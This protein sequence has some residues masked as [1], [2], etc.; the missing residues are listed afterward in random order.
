MN[1]KTTL[2][3]AVLCA[4]G[5]VFYW[6]ESSG[7]PLLRS[8]SRQAEASDLGTRNFLETELTAAK[9]S[10][11]QVQHGGQQVI[12]ERGQDG[13]WTMPGKWP[14]RKPEVDELVRLLAGLHSRF[15]PLPLGNPP[16]LKTYGLDQPLVTVTVWIDD[17]DH[18]LL[19]GEDPDETNRFPRATYVRLD[20]KEEVVRLAPGL[21]AL[22]ERPQDYY[23]QRR[24]FPSERVA[25][26]EDAQEKV[27]RLAAKSV[28][29][30]GTSGT[31]TLA[32]ASEDWELTSPVHDRPDPDKLKSILTAVPDIWAEQFV[33]KPKKDLAE[34]GLKEPEQKI[35]VTRSTG[36]TVTLLIGKQSKMKT[37]NIMRAAP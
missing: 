27:E 17:K 32:Q 26:E 3:L 20:D 11:I 4:A 31:Y 13:E 14:T 30:K 29:V 36:D 15:A 25:K 34:Y 2:V 1:L 21:A 24:L 23:Q 19:F 28:A 22:L 5:G 33:D 7:P 8:A 37:R 18:R 35:Q 10:K 6:V 16:D 9:L 12:L